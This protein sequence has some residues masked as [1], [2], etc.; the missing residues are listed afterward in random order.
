M[1]IPDGDPALMV[2]LAE[3][4]ARL[5]DASRLPKAVQTCVQN[6]AADFG[7]DLLSEV[8]QNIDQA[9]QVLKSVVTVH[10]SVRT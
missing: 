5:E 3:S 9:R 6:D 2:L 4:R 10:Q 7:V 1:K 8:A